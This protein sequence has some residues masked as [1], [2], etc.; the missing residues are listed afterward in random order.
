MIKSIIA[1]LILGVMAATATTAIAGC[2]TC[3]P[4]A[5]RC[6]QICLRLMHRHHTTST[7]PQYV[8]ALTPVAASSEHPRAVIRRPS[9][10]YACEALWH[11][12]MASVNQGAW[13]DY[14][15]AALEAAGCP[16]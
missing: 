3:N 1:S 15:S 8:I 10:S 6:R 11:A 16:L 5:P 13:W 2:N 7:H 4:N 9:T 12:L 14:Y